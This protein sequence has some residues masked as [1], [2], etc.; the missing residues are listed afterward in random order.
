V[1]RT[2]AT[3]PWTSAAIYFYAATPGSDGGYYRLDNVSL[4]HDPDSSAQQTTCLDPN[5]PAAGA[6]S[7]GPNLL[8]NGDFGSGAL[9]PGWATF[10]TITTQ[11]AGGVAQFM[12]PT[13]VAPA[14]VLLQAT[15]QALTSGE[16]LTASLQLG[17]ATGSRK[18]V[19]VILHDN[20]FTDLAACTFW[21]PPGA[22]LSTYTVRTWT[23]QS[24]TNATLSIYP[25]TTNSEWTEIDNVSLQRT[26][27]A[28]VAGT[29]CLEPGS[30]RPVSD[31]ASALTASDTPQ[32]G[33]GTPRDGPAEAGHYDTRRL[34]EAAFTLDAGDGWTL[35]ADGTLV[36]TARESG[37]F[38]L[39]LR[40]R[41]DLRDGAAAT[42]EFL[43]RLDADG[44][45]GE[46]QVRTADSEW[47]SVAQV[48]SGSLEWRSIDLSEFAGD[49]IEVRFVFHAVA[50]DP[51]DRWELSD[52]RVVR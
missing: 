50:G 29:E 14:G 30:A 34:A 7:N 47:E 51:A 48:E 8:T 27:A 28:T 41:I 16:I 44:S 3:K 31:D 21:L 12:R 5:A 20:N 40:D 52:V 37:D 39:R 10:G 1:M 32:V 38:A 49:V 15:G 17:T 23:T 4:Q 11:V 42:L 24:W 25:S 33:A 9:A 36:A 43:S 22:P 2:H 18:R 35:R 13:N 45:T 46:V 26:P 6:G 19:T